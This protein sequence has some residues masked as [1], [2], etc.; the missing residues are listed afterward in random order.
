MCCHFALEWENYHHMER[1]PRWDVQPHA[2]A[3]AKA[4]CK[5]ASGPSLWALSCHSHKFDDRKPEREIRDEVVVHHVEQGLR[6]WLV[7]MTPELRWPPRRQAIRRT[8]AL[9][10]AAALIALGG[11]PSRRSAQLPGDY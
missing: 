11:Q 7:A 5:R 9:M 4:F 6:W 3:A 1:V 2:A 8:P 10:S